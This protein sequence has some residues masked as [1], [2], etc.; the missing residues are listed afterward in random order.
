MSSQAH[1]HLSVVVA[2]RNDGHGGDIVKRMKLFLQGLLDQSR[3]YRFPME[4]IFVEWNPPADRPPLRDVLPKPCEQDCLTLRY[5]TVPTSIHDRY[6]RATEIPLFQMIAKNVGIRRAK[7]DYVLCTNID[8]LFS[9]ALFRRLAEAAFRGDTFYRAN[10]CDVPDGID[11]AWDLAQQLAW[12]E[13]NIIRRLGRDLR[14]KNI[15][16][17]LVGLRSDNKAKKWLFDKLALGMSVFWTREKRLFYQ[18]DSFACGDFTMMSRS[19]WLAIKG[20]PELDLYSL[21]VDSLG[22][23]A[24]A[25]LDFKQHVFPPEAC[26]YHI[27]HPS[28]WEALSPLEKVRFLEKRPA[29]DFGLVQELGLYALGRREAPDLNPSNW[30]YS[31]T[32]L[33]EWVFAGHSAN[34]R[35]S[36]CDAVSLGN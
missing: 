26:T 16:L 17:E 35:I 5:I 6:R 27:D 13:K 15:N 22:L 20:Y 10:R 36:I 30:G 2:S 18:L 32:E 19:A 21:H 9:D 1:P 7:G 25:S 34:D 4:V 3:H 24:A 14:Y 31:T 28:G 8:L 12:C 33:D 23:I 11:P 29:I